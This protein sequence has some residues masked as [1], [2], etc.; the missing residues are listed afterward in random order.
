MRYVILFICY[1]VQVNAN[2]HFYYCEYVEEDEE[3]VTE[4]LSDGYET[5]KEIT[6]TDLVNNYN[7]LKFDKYEIYVP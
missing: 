3:L 1:W 7:R 4:Y 2:Y 5:P 6:Y